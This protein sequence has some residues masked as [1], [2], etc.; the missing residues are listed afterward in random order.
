MP[1]KPRR[2][3]RVLY[4]GV[5]IVF[6]L[7]VI[8]LVIGIPVG[9][10]TTVFGDNPMRVHATVPAQ[11]V[12]GLPAHI[13]SD[14]VEVSV[15]IDHLTT[16]QIV[17]FN[18]LIALG[19]LLILYALWQLR[20]L[21]GSIRAA[22]PFSTDNVRRLRA[23]GWLFLAAYPVFQYVTGGVNEW[24]LST[25]GP[26]IAGA[27]VDIDPFSIW[28]VFGGLVLLVLA[29]V[30]GHGLRLREDVEATI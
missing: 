9:V 14:G 13:A 12:S 30:F 2:S 7:T 4:L 16:P 1:P 28:A 8:G 27:R 25:G 19:G 17:V 15:P 21:V 23:L 11:A 29:E 5:T 24:I 26:D 10:A 3:V 20:R 22:D 6:W 18:A